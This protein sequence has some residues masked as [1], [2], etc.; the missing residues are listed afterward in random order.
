MLFNFNPLVLTL[1]SF[2]GRTSC[3]LLRLQLSKPHINFIT[4]FPA[5]G[6]HQNA[7]IHSENKHPK[8]PTHHVIDS[9][10]R[11]GQRWQKSASLRQNVNTLLQAPANTVASNSLS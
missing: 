9:P 10:G 2:I 1:T 3:S 7:H 6:Y 8:K 4:A 5:V 11:D